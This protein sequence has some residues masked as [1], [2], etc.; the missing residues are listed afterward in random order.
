MDSSE[1]QLGKEDIDRN[2]NGGIDGLEDRILL[3]DCGGVVGTEDCGVVGVEDC[4]TGGEFQ[5]RS[6]AGESH[7]HLFC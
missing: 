3:D 1:Q 2:K 7:M 4:R 5:S 6:I